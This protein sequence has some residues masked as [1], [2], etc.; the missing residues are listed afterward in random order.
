[1]VFWLLNIMTFKD[2]GLKPI[3]LIVLTALRGLI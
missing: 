3:V 2:N 1:M